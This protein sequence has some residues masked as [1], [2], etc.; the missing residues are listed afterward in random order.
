MPLAGLNSLIEP[1]KSPYINL[2]EPI[3]CHYIVAKCLNLS[4][5]FQVSL[6]T[7]YTGR[8]RTHVLGWIG[9]EN[10][11]ADC[12][13]LIWYE[14]RRVIWRFGFIEKLSLSVAEVSLSDIST[15]G[16][17][18]RFMMWP[19]DDEGFM[20]GGSAT[21]WVICCWDSKHWQVVPSFHHR[22]PRF[23]VIFQRFI[24]THSVICCWDPEHWQLRRLAVSC[25]CNLIKRRCQFFSG[26]YRSF[27]VIFQYF[28]EN[29]RSWT[30]EN[31]Q[32]SGFRVMLT[33]TGETPDRNAV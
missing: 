14:S 30:C 9:V 24:A 29:K 23:L 31:E 4:A 12:S 13:F 2:E 1:S 27:L 6:V 19:M 26:C 33:I 17:V 16:K 18:E 20:A 5:D 32:W 7:E 28:I 21:H 3:V 22:H 15:I 10:D 8:R 11:L 25:Q